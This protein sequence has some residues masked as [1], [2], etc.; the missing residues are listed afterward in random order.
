MFDWNRNANKIIDA[1]RERL[2][3]LSE[4][5]LMIEII[6]ELQKINENCDDIGRKIVV[7]S[8]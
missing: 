6:I 8:D 2:R 1:E 5:E 4:K 7:W 3:N